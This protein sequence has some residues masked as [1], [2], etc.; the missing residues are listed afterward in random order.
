MA[1]SK[2][3]HNI[4]F[5]INKEQFRVTFNSPWIGDDARLQQAKRILEADGS[6][7]KKLEALFGVFGPS[8]WQYRVGKVTTSVEPL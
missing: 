2:I 6:M 3:E 4:N 1:Y 8:A 7:E 5:M